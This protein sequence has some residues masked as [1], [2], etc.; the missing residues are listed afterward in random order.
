[1]KKW[2]PLFILVVFSFSDLNAQWSAVGTGMDANV[3]SLS[4]YNTEL[5]AGGFFTM[6]GGA[7][8]NR[9][10]KWDGTN[11]ST[12]GTGMNAN[13][14]ALCIYNGELYAGGSFTTAGGTQ[15]CHPCPSRNR[16]RTSLPLISFMFPL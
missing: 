15:S 3:N 2:L 11:W 8:A 14:R 7:P 5:Y 6:A 13:V 10:A 9:I 12:A 1:M 4:T 16:R